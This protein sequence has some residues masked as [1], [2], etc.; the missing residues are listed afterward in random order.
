VTFVLASLLVLAAAY[1]VACFVLWSGWKLFLPGTSTPFVPI[2]GFAIFLFWLRQ[3]ALLQRTDSYWLG[4]RIN[5]PPSK[6]ENGV[7]GGRLVPNR[8]D[9]WRCGRSRQWPSRCGHS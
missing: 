2:D 9:R 5:H 1:L 3:V 7:A 6:I 8:I 4:D